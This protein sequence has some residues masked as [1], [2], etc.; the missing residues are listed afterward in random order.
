[1]KSDHTTEYK[2]DQ[3]TSFEM[4]RNAALEY[5]VAG[6]ME[7]LDALLNDLM[8][9]RYN[10]ILE[11]IHLLPLDLRDRKFDSVL[12]MAAY[13]FALN[14][15]IKIP[16]AIFLLDNYGY[17]T[18]EQVF[19][20][21]TTMFAQMNNVQGAHTFLARMRSNK[22]V[23]EKHIPY[24]TGRM[25][26]SFYLAGRNHEDPW[27]LFETELTESTLSTMMSSLHFSQFKYVL[28]HVQENYPQLTEAG[29]RKYLEEKIRLQNEKPFDNTTSQDIFKML[30]ICKTCEQNNPS[31]TPLLARMPLKE[32][33]YDVE[34]LGKRVAQAER[35]AAFLG[36][37]HLS[38]LLAWRDPVIRFIL[39]AENFSKKFPFDIITHVVTFLSP[40]CLTDTRAM[41]LNVKTNRSIL[42]QR[43]TL[44]TPAL[45]IEENKQ[46]A[47]VIHLI[48]DETK[49][50]AA[51]EVPKPGNKGK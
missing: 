19:P 4:I 8:M 6:E 42:F 48:Q 35:R 26:A 3:L 16:D 10:G 46:P 1:M 15:T 34:H 14:E 11:K 29:M 45:L 17:H 36:F 27:R 32:A 44:P 24:L 41:V 23:E 13:G 40:R 2:P 50:E 51:L 37:T 18:A 49:P 38:H 5:A 43:M 31:M 28:K 47:A 22:D 33:G 12:Q 21:I 30:L 9:G 25:A 20:A 7:N 39:L